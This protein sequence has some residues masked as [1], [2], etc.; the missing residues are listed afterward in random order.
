LEENR[1]KIR[2]PEETAKAARR[3]RSGPPWMRIGGGLFVLLSIVLSIV[4]FSR[5]DLFS[6][7]GQ[8]PK[9][10]DAEQQEVAVLEKPNSQVVAS[11]TQKGTIADDG[12]SLWVSPTA[13]K[14]LDLGYLLPGTQLVLH[15]RVA[16]LLA[17]AEGEKILAAIGPWG[18]QV[19]QKITRVTGVALS[20]I[21]TLLLGIRLAR[22]GSMEY[23]VRF[24]LIGGQVLVLCPTDALAKLKANTSQAPLFARELQR[25]LQRTDTARMATLVFSGKFL[26]ISGKKFLH[27]AGEPL[28]VAL[29]DFLGE[30]A[31]A[32]AISMHWDDNFFLELL[33]T[34]TLDQRPHRFAALLE[35][36]VAASADQVENV[37]LSKPPSPYGRKVLV[38]F[39]AMLQELGNYTRSGEEDGLSLLRAYLPVSAGHNLVMATELLLA[40]GASHSDSGSLEA[41]SNR[42]AEP[43]TLAQRLQQTTSL[44]FPKETLQKALEILSA[45][46]GLPLR[47]AGRDLQ[48][49]GITK[50]QSLGIDLRDR[51][52]AEILLEILLRANPDRT[53]SGPTDAKQ[54]LVYVLREAVE[55]ERGAIVVTTRSAARRRGEKLPAVFEP[56][57]H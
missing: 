43:R 5:S 38:R 20:E 3:R 11:R 44:V 53:A 42:S 8:R 9:S 14:P 37:L 35:K 47:I 28:R 27:D 50:N 33:S 46:L 15:V 26:Q 13:G 55:G 54:K 18:H 36:R 49:E 24:C 39:P 21:E 30:E 31:T 1:L 34:V 25:V 6:R 2:I 17:H 56:V 41:G 40:D 29:I 4:L 32:T 57:T 52:A 23:T 19:S 16:D 51:L 22:G 12:Q 7:S 48:L 45:D 10:H